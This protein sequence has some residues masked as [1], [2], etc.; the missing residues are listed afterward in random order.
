MAVVVGQ[1]HIVVAGRPEGGFKQ[2]EM[3][4]RHL[5]RE[6]RV[7]LPHLLCKRNALDPGCFDRSPALL[8]LADADRRDEGAHADAGGPQV[9]DLIDLEAGVNL[10]G[11]R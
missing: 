8:V 10:A 1:D 3:D 7:L 2:P 4:R 6:D 9:V 5:R 11:V